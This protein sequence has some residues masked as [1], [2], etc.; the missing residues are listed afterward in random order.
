VGSSETGPTV[1]VER[2]MVGTSVGDTGVSEG[3]GDWEVGNNVMGVSIAGEP[4]KGAKEGSAIG[5]T[6]TGNIVG[7]VEA[8]NEV[9]ENTGAALGIS[10]GKIV[11]VAYTEKQ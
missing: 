8:S 6:V 2:N 1:A 4:V 11:T 10:E 9:G 3:A 7:M 5:S